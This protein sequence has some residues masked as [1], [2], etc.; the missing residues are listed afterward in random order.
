MLTLVTAESKRHYTQNDVGLAEQLASRAALAVDNARLYSQARDE[1]E[2]FRIT[3]S[4]IGDAVIAT[5]R[6]GRITFLNQVAADLTGW[7][8]DEAQDQPLDTVFTIINEDTRETVENP[9]AKV[10]HEGRVVGLANHTLLVSKSGAEIPI[11]DSGAPIP[12]EASGVVLVFRD[13]S[14]RRQEASRQKFLVDASELLGSSLDYE[15]TLRNVV[16]LAVP[17]IAD[18]CAVDLLTPEGAIRRV[19]VAHVD[20]DKVKWAYEILERF[21]TNLNATNGVGWVLRNGETEFVP[22]VPTLMAP[23]YDALPDELKQIVDSLQ[24]ISVITTPLRVSGTTFGALTLAT[25]ESERRYSQIDVQFAEALANRA[26]LAV[27]NARL[28]AE[29]EQE[30]ERF[31][32]TLS[33]IGDAVIATDQ[34]GQV[35]FINPIA[36]H[37]T[38][39]SADDALGKPLDVI[40]NIINEQSRE[41]VE[42]PVYRVLREGVVVGLANH[43]VLVSKSGAETPIDD[44]G[45]PIPA[46]EG[47][48]GGVVLV[49]RDVSERKRAEQRQQ[50]LAEAGNLL[51]SS[52][53]YD[54]T[55]QQIVRLAVP[56]LADWAIIYLLDED[57]I[58]NATVREAAAYHVDPAKIALREEMMRRY[59]PA[60]DHVHGYPRVIRTGEPELL[61]G[62]PDHLENIARDAEHLRYLRALNYRSSVTVPLKNLERTFGAFALA[63]AES[64]RDFNR[65]D[66]VLLEE[67]GKLASL[68]VE[69]AR[70]YRRAQRSDPSPPDQHSD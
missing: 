65:A 39:W 51:I 17:S 10:I 48:I 60:N 29:A 15:T 42:S 31:Q 67:L 4:S 44:S 70:L 24:A 12:G 33:S 8:V 49:F 28:H 20:P 50:F 21:P 35:T 43:T 40:F 38:G 7:S 3:L 36:A 69:N 5:D 61:T 41:A 14:A 66:L 19:N 54:T 56:S 63:T 32:V 30:R 37:L 62:L 9:V 47:G 45:A 11:D 68:A 55:L 57:E 58:G 6:Q 27:D 64:A 2:R 46:R 18:W 23:I 22:D 53:D 26:A 16:K 13:V 59:T 34:Q 1:R 52:L 25:A